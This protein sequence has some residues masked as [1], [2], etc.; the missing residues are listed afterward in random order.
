VY[1]TEAAEEL[2]EA[3]RPA[4]LPVLLGVLPLRT[5]AHAEFLH[6]RVA[7]IGVPLEARR[8]MAAA[9]DPAAAGVA[10]AGEMLAEAR[11][12]FRGACLMPPFGHYEILRPLLA[13][14]PERS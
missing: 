12:L 2:A 8:R 9:A 7:G 10:L 6:R 11:R 13:G 1:S 5:P 14:G 3:A 4:G